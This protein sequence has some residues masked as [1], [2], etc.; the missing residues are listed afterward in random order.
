MKRRDFN[1]M[2]LGAGLQ[3]LVIR[4]H[5]RA[6]VRGAIAADPTTSTKV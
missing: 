1:R 2:A 3:P 5:T 4:P 6:V